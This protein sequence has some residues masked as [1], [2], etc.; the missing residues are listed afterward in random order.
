MDILKLSSDDF[1]K[2]T[3]TQLKQAFL[4]CKKRSNRLIE[5]LKNKV[6]ALENQYING[7]A[8]KLITDVS[9]FDNFQ[10]NIDRFNTINSALNDSM[11]AEKYIFNF[12]KKKKFQGNPKMTAVFFGKTWPNQVKDYFYFNDKRNQIEAEV[13]KTIKSITKNAQK[14]VTKTPAQIIP[15]VFSN[16]SNP[17]SSNSTITQTIQNVA[18]AMPTAPSTSV[19]T[20]STVTTA[21]PVSQPSVS[22]TTQNVSSASNASTYSVTQAVQTTYVDMTDPNAGSVQMIQPVNTVKGT[23]ES[24]VEKHKST[25][26]KWGW[27]IVIGSISIYATVTIRKM[28]SIAKVK[29]LTRKAIESTNYKELTKYTNALK[30]I[31]RNEGIWNKLVMTEPAVELANINLETIRNGYIKV[32]AS[33]VISSLL[34]CLILGLS[35]ATTVKIEKL[36]KNLDCKG[37]LKIIGTL[38]A[39][40]LVLLPAVA[41]ICLIVV[42]LNGLTDKG[43]AA[44]FLTKFSPAIRLA[45]EYLHTFA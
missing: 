11:N 10:E 35:I 32:G 14:A 17:I 19:A 3:D 42:A 37:V 36:L 20:V 24:F 4:E 2:L 15:K 38:S 1:K 44:Y 41:G 21:S 13:Q 22:Q 9:V 18:S 28:Y 5:A 33:L 16:T 45:N 26:N 40:A 23:A 39:F 7:T 29:E 25:I 12:V 34:L 43:I 31:A 6:N 30:K 27:G 8:G